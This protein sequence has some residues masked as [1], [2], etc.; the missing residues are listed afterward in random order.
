MRIKAH[1]VVTA[2]LVLC[3]FVSS[4]SQEEPNPDPP[5][6]AAQPAKAPAAQAPATNVS[7]IV[8]VDEKDACEC[9]RERVQI[10]WAS[11][12]SAL[13]GREDIPVERIYNDTEPEKVAPY[14]EMRA[15]MVIPA[16]YFLDASG[17]LIDRVQGEITAERFTKAL[18]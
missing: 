8:F 4:C 18:N 16:V 17:G 3:A 12:Q 6:V 1:I 14:K 7:K 13:A 9:T 2:S 15:F 10:S 11:L 5:P